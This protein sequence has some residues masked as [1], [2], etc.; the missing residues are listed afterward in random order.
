MHLVRHSHVSVWTYLRYRVMCVI[1]LSDFN[2]IWWTFLDI[3]MRYPQHKI[4][5]ISFQWVP[6]RYMRN[7]RT[8]HT[9]GRIWRS[10]FALFCS[11]ANAHRNKLYPVVCF[12]WFLVSLP[13]LWYISLSGTFITLF[14]CF[15][16]QIPRCTKA[17]S[18]TMFLDHTQRRTTDRRILLDEW[19]ARRRD[20]Y[21]TTHNTHNKHPC[22]WWDSKPQSQ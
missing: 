1:F 22:P 3:F 9:G 15:W 4:S 10:W 19:S 6:C 13:L 14:V 11:H 8:R 18:F 17:S 20:L 16:R 2:Q 7:D 21:L 12:I 5:L